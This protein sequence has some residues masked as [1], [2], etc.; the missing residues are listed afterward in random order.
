MF[1]SGLCIHPFIDGNGRVSRLLTVLMLYIF[2]Y[3]IGRYI[4][5]ENQINIRK[6]IMQHLNSLH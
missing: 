1:Y 3:D 5:V 2:G 4:S 6:A